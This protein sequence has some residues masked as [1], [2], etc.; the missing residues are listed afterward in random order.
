MSRSVAR[1]GRGPRLPA[2]Q[3]VALIVLRSFIGWHFLYEGYYKWALPG[4]DRA[5]QP[6][7]DWSAEAYLAAA[8]GPLAGVFHWLAASPL[9]AWVDALIVAAMIAAGLSLLLG[10]WTQAGGWVALALL[11]LFY[12]AQ[13]PLAGRPGPGSEGAYLLV[14]KNLIEWAAVLTL[15]VFRTGRIA[16]LDLLRPRRGGWRAGMEPDAATR[17]TEPEPSLTGRTHG[18]HA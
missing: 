1:E 9:L 7:A 12:L 6:M 11:S 14:N 5:G 10:L 18:A 3:Q 2:A 13:I 4:W 15:L 16:G 8:T 17:R